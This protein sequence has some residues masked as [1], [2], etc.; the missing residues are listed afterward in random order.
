[1]YSQPMVDKNELRAAFSAR[2]HK[3]LDDADVRTRGRGVDIHKRLKSVGLHKT[4]QAIS[5]WLNGEAL[6]ESDSIAA[7]SAWLKVRREW[8]Q[9]GVLPKSDKFDCLSEH[10]NQR[11]TDLNPSI[12]ERVPLITWEQVK[13]Y[14]V[15][16]LDPQALG[17][18]EWISSPV[19]IGWRGFAVTVIGDS[20]TNLSPG[21]SYPLGSIIYVDPDQS[22][23]PGKA[24]IAQVPGTKDLTFKQLVEDAGRRY[25]RPLNPQYPIIDITDGAYI[26]GTVI[27]KFILH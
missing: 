12:V 25:L 4:T 9:Y 6:P 19:E 15:I 14:W 22:A 5:K 18:T 17:V 27:G 11:L 21:K 3:C 2:L 26:S 8:L 23:E 7:L 1:M 20:M 24:V 16:G 10:Y 13:Q